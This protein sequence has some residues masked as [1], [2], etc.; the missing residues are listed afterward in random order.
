LRIQELAYLPAYAVAFTGGA[1]ILLNGRRWLVLA[2]ACQYFMTAWL[3]GLVLPV[4]VASIKLVAGLMSCTILAVSL[5]YSS[6]RAQVDRRHAIPSNR[7]FRLIAVLLVLIAIGSIG[8]DMWTFLPKLQ[9]E[10]S[11]GSAL[12]MS[13]ALLQLG[14]SEEP[15]RIGIGLLTLLSGFEVVYSAIE[16]AR[17]V[18]ALLAAIHM[19]IALVIGYITL[20]P[21]REIQ[22]EEPSL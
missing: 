22:S 10:A 12:M 18:L 4:E 21:R 11:L 1:L 13:F 5:S 15:L 8:Q 20:M 19:G 17:A 3:V 2:L 6:W 16:P 7:L 14:I 9:S